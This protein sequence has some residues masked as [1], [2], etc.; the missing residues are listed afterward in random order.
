MKTNYFRS[1]NIVYDADF[2]ER[3][4]HYRPTGKASNLL[5]S[6]YGDRTDKAYF[7]VAPYGSGKSLTATFLLQIIEN[8]DKSKPY[9]DKICKRLSKYDAGLAQLFYDRMDKD[10]RGL[11]ITLNGSYENIFESM[12]ESLIDSCNRISIDY[13]LIED[14]RSQGELN[15]SRFISMLRLIDKNASLLGI[16][17]LSILWDEFGRY[18]EHI[19]QEGRSEE[20]EFIQLLAEYLNRTGIPMS[21]GLFLHQGVMNYARNVT[22]SVRSEW[23]KI[24]GRFKTI[25]YTDD[26]KELY[27]LISEV[28]SDI[29]GKTHNNHYLRYID[30][31]KKLG[32][33]KDVL[34]IELY[35]IVDK[36]YPLDPFAFFLLPKIS[37]RVAQNE[38]TLFTFISTLSAN[39][40]VSVEDLFDYFSDAMLADKGIGG[41]YK[42]YIETRS[43]ISKVASDMLS[44]RILKTACLLGLGSNG[45]R[46]HV[47]MDLLTYAVGFNKEKHIKEKIQELLDK[48]LLLYRKLHD[49]ISV[50]HG[51]DLDLNGRLNEERKK[52]SINFDLLEFLTHEVPAPNWKP[53]EYNSKYHIRRYYTGSYIS[54]EELVALTLKDPKESL[55]T[56]VDGRVLY[57]LPA[58]DDEYKKALEIASS[59]NF[60]TRIVIAIPDK[61][62]NLYETALDVKSLQNLQND[63]ALL[64]EDPLILPEL[65]QLSDDSRTYLQSLVDRIIMPRKNGTIWFS[66]KES[67]VFANKSDLR[68]WLSERME[69]S[70]GSTPIIRNELIVRR[71]PTGVMVNARKRLIFAILDQSGIENLG[72]TGN[73]PDMSMFRTVLLHTGIYRKDESGRWCWANP[74]DLDDE[75]LKDVWGRFQNFFTHGRDKQK[76]FEVL[77]DTVQGTPYGLRD[78]LIPILLAAA[79]RAFPSAVHITRKGQYLTDILPSTIENICR[80]PGEYDINIVDLDDK[81][82][83]YLQSLL[84]LFSPTPDITQTEND[85]VRSCFD[86]IEL[87][88][89]KLPAAGLHTKKISKVA[90][91]FQRAVVNITNPVDVFMN[92][93]PT[94]LGSTL[95]DI[96][97][98]LSRLQQVKQEI[99][100]VSLIY[101]KFACKELLNALQVFD[102]DSSVSIQEIVRIWISALP[103]NTK[104]KLID[105]SP[106]G[107]L[108]TAKMSYKTNFDYINAVSTVILDKPISSWSDPDIV[109]FDNKIHVVINTIEEAALMVEGSS[110]DR[111]FVNSIAKITAIRIESMYVNLVKKCGE[112]KAKAI[113]NEFV[114]KKGL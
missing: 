55:P 80:F 41:T 83:E 16:D 77:F 21:F 61:C 27:A 4:S 30:K 84:K 34:D 107:I 89:S 32:L 75:G 31:I 28:I 79:F 38:R 73:K 39:T 33:F 2:P 82:R 58:S 69:R 93:I 99:E 110:D 47:S 111:E 59:S 45:E 92:K 105:R 67:Q 94:I 96:D 108:N 7:V 102:Y 25:H 98:L 91:R 63:Q 9:L 113:F 54:I 8:S 23:K 101:A 56:S 53:L 62:Y 88:K 6:L 18:L 90:Q 86:A 14:F 12:Y 76:S 37:M 74:E 85:Y 109:L 68:L 13:S 17:R 57:C 24:E 46:A 60:G 48:K 65:L 87:W 22:Q 26:N 43:A 11:V 78:G 104:K 72:M 97:T 35:H 10:N 52:V 64:G 106:K 1:I 100:G 36:A 81:K 20:L 44:V 42:Q 19:V 70:F 95:D 40:I 29:I 5:R 114:E 50:W 51:A 66:E 3:I 15:S 103:K 49:D 71:N 112:E